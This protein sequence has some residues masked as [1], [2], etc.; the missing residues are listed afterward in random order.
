MKMIETG[1]NVIR[2]ADICS[3]ITVLDSLK[4]QPHDRDPKGFG[5]SLTLVLIFLF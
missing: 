4:T 3:L 2:F 1:V 5:N